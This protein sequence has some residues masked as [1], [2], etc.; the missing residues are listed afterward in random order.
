[1]PHIR[2]LRAI[3]SLGGGPAVGG[4]WSD[5]RLA[6]SDAELPRLTALQ[7]KPLVDGSAWHASVLAGKP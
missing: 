2:P 1:M 6:D 4:S 5:D 3:P 7:V